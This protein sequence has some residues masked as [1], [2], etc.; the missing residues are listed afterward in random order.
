[1]RRG[2]AFTG[3]ALARIVVAALDQLDI[4]AEVTFVLFLKQLLGRQQI[5][6]AAPPGDRHRDVAL[7]DAR[8]RFQAEDRRRLGIVGRV[9]DG[10]GQIRQEARLLGTRRGVWREVLEQVRS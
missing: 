2:D 9:G 8:R 1:M 4:P 10:R 7:A 3:R 5:A 6:A